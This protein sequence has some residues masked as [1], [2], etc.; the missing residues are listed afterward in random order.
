MSPEKTAGRTLIG[1]KHSY[2]KTVGPFR[3][4]YL[5]LLLREINVQFS[6]KTVTIESQSLVNL[7]RQLLLLDVICGCSQIQSLVNIGQMLIVSYKYSSVVNK[8]A[9]LWFLLIRSAVNIGQ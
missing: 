4:N 1:Q 3:V 6:N 2:Q 8:G 5:F 7:A 9:F